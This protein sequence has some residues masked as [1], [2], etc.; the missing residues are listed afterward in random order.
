MSNRYGLFKMPNKRKFLGH[1]LR[2][3]RYFDIVEGRV[4]EYHE[5]SLRYDNGD[6]K[7]AYRVWQGDWPSG[8]YNPEQAIKKI[9][10]MRNRKDAKTN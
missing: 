7:Q 3:G 5:G 1:D 9:V 6:I 10:A 8:A 4:A 2:A